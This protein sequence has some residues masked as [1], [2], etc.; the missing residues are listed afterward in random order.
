MHKEASLNTD[1]NNQ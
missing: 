1:E